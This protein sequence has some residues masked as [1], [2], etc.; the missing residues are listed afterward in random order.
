M[1]TNPLRTRLYLYN[2]SD[3]VTILI[4]ST[5]DDW[6]AIWLD[7]R[8]WVQLDEGDNA[9]QAWWLKTL[10]ATPGT[11]YL[12]VVEFFASKETPKRWW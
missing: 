11:A 3:S 10:V 8:R 1:E 5:N 9:A 2:Q 7:P 4:Y 6:G 12:S